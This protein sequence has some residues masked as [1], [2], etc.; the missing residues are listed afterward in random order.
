MKM[1]EAV[2]NL[3]L[4][5]NCNFQKTCVIQSEPCQ[6][7]ALK[8]YRKMFINKPTLKSGDR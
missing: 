4:P 6:W 5:V 3:E 8:F 2:M 1:T 7:L